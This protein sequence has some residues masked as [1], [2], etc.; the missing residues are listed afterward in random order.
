LLLFLT[1]VSCTPAPP[2]NK[3]ETAPAPA[4]SPERQA[5][6]TRA[7][8]RWEALISRDYAAAYGYNTPAFRARIPLQAFTS[9]FGND[10][11]WKQAQVTAVE[12]LDEHKAKVTM[13]VLYSPVSEVGEIGGLRGVGGID[14]TW[15]NADGTWWIDLPD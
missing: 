10:I 6:E 13:A 7:T 12:M 3:A 5:L 4:V 2:G 1:L 15:V 14:E 11:L 9:R 8:A